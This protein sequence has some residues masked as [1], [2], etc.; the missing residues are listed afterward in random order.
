MNRSTRDSVFP[1]D[2]PA[3]HA[4]NTVVTIVAIRLSALVL[5]GEHPASGFS[6]P[7]YDGGRCWDIT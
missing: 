2:S 1:I 7:S 3:Q 5:L 6:G 4:Y